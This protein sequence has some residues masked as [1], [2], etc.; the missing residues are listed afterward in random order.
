MEIMPEF[1]ETENN[2]SML[3]TISSEETGL[4]FYSSNFMEIK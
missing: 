4:G 3:N 2:I 1:H